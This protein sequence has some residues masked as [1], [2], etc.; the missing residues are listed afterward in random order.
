MNEASPVVTDN[1]P[2]TTENKYLF[3]PQAL[4]NFKVIDVIA[5][6]VIYFVLARLG[7]QF[8]IEPG[9]VTP[10]WIPSGVCLAIALTRGIRVWPGIFLGAFVGNVWSYFSFDSPISAAMAGTLNGIGDVICIVGMA[11][12]IFRYSGSSNPLHSR[13]QFVYF[14]VLGVILG[15]FISAVFGVFGLYLFGFIPV[16]SVQITFFTWWIGDAVGVLL[17]A[18]L[19]IAW[20][21]PEQ[22]QHRHRGIALTMLLGIAYV[23]M[24]TI[25]GVIEIPRPIATIGA[26]LL[27]LALITMV[28]YGQRTLFTVQALALSVAIYATSNGLGPFASTEEHMA[29]M[30]LQWFIAIFSCAIFGLAVITFENQ[31]AK[32]VILEK[33]EELESLYRTDHLTGVANRHF[34]TEFLAKEFARMKRSKIPF[35]VL[36]IDLDDFKSVN[37]TLGHN[38]GD[39]VLNG[40]CETIAP[41]IRTNDLLGRWGGEEFIVICDNVDQYSLMAVA[42]KIRTE[43]EQAS[44]HHNLKI[45]I[46]IGATLASETDTQKSLTKRADMALYRSKENFKNCV[47]F[48]D[49]DEKFSMENKNGAE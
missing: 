2:A 14:V 9:N 44:F 11:Y 45:T 41:I 13:T 49:R 40:L 42:E 33:V 25:F 19:V 22:I 20:L 8:A 23:S 10:V 27:P 15:P 5:I 18:P 16:D 38:V 47:T 35:G 48:I 29:L 24:A 43:V 12:L 1:E 30:N 46:S 37:D 6:A 7:Q 39:R 32:K 26:V 17:F 21:H 36:L 3:A 28:H 34:I 4:Y 31:H